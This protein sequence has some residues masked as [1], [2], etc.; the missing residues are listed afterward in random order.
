[1]ITTGTCSLIASLAQNKKKKKKTKQNKKENF[2]KQFIVRE[3][4]KSSVT[5]ATTVTGPNSL[6][7]HTWTSCI[8]CCCCCCLFFCVDP[9]N[10]GWTNWTVWFPCSVSCGGGIQISIRFCT[11]PYPARDGKYCVGQSVKKQ[12][13]NLQ[14]CPCKYCAL[15]FLIYILIT[16]GRTTAKLWGTNNRGPEQ[17]RI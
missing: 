16:D 7:C 11:K 12:V 9:I 10:G 6:H 2:C 14:H 4:I 1:M 13:C 8:I 5:M 3:F 15:P 17:W